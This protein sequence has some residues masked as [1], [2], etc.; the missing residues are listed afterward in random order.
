MPSIPD[1]TQSFA[2][3]N[4]RYVWGISLAA[5]LGGLMFGY[6]WIVIGGTKHFYERFFSLT[7]AWQQG[8]AMASALLGCLLGAVLS[9]MLSD[10]FGRKRLLIL[11]A[12]V[13][14]VSSL[15]TALAGQFWT[16]NLWRIA[17]GV[18]IGLASNLSP[19]Y[20]AEVA[21][22]AVRGRLVAMN[23]LMIV[24]GILSAQVVNFGIDQ[25][26][27]GID[28]Q[29]LVESEAAESGWNAAAVAEEL[30][31][32]LKEKERKAFIDDFTA[33]A[34]KRTSPLDHEGVAAIVGEI[35]RDREKPPVNTDDKL[36]LETVGRGMTPLS[37]SRG[38]RWMFGVTALPALLFFVMMFLVPESPRWLIKNGKSGRARAVLAR[39]GGERFAE[40]ETAN[41]E[42][43]LV[44]E[45]EKVNFR[46]L[47]APRLRWIITVGVVFAVLQQWC[48]MNVIFYYAADLFR[49]AGYT[50]SA[51]LFNIVIIGA[52]NLTFTVVAL[53]CVD[54]FGRRI[55]LLIGFA[56]LA[57]LHLLIGAGYQSGY[58]GAF[59]LLL[60]LAAIGLYGLSLAPVTWVVLSEIF[61]NR[62]RGAAMSISVFALWAG[63]FLLTLTYPLLEEGIGLGW[64]FWVYGGICAAGF[65]FCARYL[66]ETK[67][68]TLEEI[69]KELVD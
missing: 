9:G 58:G 6:D 15:G 69:E 3:Y 32:N 36:V 48:G 12:L 7:T 46:D 17:G 57:L 66:P 11:A 24:I 22:A 13:F 27:R 30:A 14:V 60:M 5:A 62:I 8:W 53:G 39:I 25:A 35:Y 55:L 34:D 4:M 20:I 63:C 16:F 52:V 10:R 37:I 2:R 29:T 1:S 23:Q 45:I 31:W 51:A 65:L 43:T 33:L 47:L 49:A 21:P 50:V 44:G 41:I 26:T 64:T 67:G 61:P 68:K 28:Q 42:A 40:S 18:A 59:I 56:G 19:M 54:R 38:W